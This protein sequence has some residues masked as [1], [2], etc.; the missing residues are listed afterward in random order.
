MRKVPYFFIALFLA[1]ITLTSCRDA[2]PTD[3]KP[4]SKLEKAADKVEDAGKRAKEEV[5]GAAD[6]VKEELDGETDDN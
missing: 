6:D 1:A 4:G 5:K 2:K 3:D